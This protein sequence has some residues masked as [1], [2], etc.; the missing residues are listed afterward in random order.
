[1]TDRRNFL[2]AG[3]GAVAAVRAGIV[4]GFSAPP[5]GRRMMPQ[6]LRLEEVTFSELADGLQSGRYS[7]R[8]VVESYLARI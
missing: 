7:A 5:P 3:L 2:T 6:E 1:M 4:A 8:G